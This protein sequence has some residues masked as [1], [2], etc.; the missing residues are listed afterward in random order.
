MLSR[1]LA[2][3]VFPVLLVG[4][5][6]WAQQSASTRPG[7][8]LE[9]ETGQVDLG[10]LAGEYCSSDTTSGG[11]RLELRGGRYE[12][13]HNKDVVG[14]STERVTGTATATGTVLELRPA[15]LRRPATYVPVSWGSRVYLIPEHEIPSFCSSR[16]EPVDNCYSSVSRYFVRTTDGYT[17]DGVVTKTRPA[18][19]Q[20][21]K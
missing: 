21:S 1:L 10:A 9:T 19:C 17:P 7:S 20:A 6:S 3:I 14:R 15:P 4:V 18:I 2:A 16:W 11:L 12:L 8:T 5:I 13:V